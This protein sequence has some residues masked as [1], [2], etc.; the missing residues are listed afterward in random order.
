MSEETVKIVGAMIGAFQRGDA[1]AALSHYSEDAVFEPLVAGPYHGRAGVA[2]QM[3]VWMEEFDQYWFESNELI[4]VG[5][6]V[7]LVF[8][9]GG[10]GRTSGIPTA[11]SGATVF[12]VTKGLISHARVFADRSEA[13]ANA[14]SEE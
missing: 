9:H 7:V 6:Q 8:R 5:E 1:E 14:E 11:D 4:V 10:K 13:L 2:E 12:T 3:T